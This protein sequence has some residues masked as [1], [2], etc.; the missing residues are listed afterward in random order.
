MNG[1]SANLMFE[2]PIVND[3]LVEFEEC[4]AVSISLPSPDTDNLLLSI[5]DGSDAA[6]S[7]IQDDDGKSV[8]LSPL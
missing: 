7:C 2:V 5:G 4:F 3:I 6:T 1:P 8:R